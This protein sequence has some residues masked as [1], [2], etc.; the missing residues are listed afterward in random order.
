ALEDAEAEDL[1]AH[2]D[3]PVP[4]RQIRREADVDREGPRAL[5]DREGVARDD[6]GG[7]AREGR[8]DRPRGPQEE[9]AE[10][11]ARERPRPDHVGRAAI[12]RDRAWTS[13]DIAAYTRRAITSPIRRARSRR[14]VWISA[15]PARRKPTAPR[16]SSLVRP[17]R[18]TVGGSS[19]RSVTTAWTAPP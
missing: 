8:E 11:E 2:R 15:T 1:R 13:S 14:G 6:A 4:R 16:V 12:S 9:R 5:R 19:G 3:R 18:P 17:S 7:H 10:G